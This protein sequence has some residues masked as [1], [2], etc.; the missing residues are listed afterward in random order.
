MNTPQPPT[1]IY[2]PPSSKMPK[3]K[4]KSASTQRQNVAAIQR[5]SSGESGL[6]FF[7]VQA[8]RG[9]GYFSLRR[10]DGKEI[11]GTP[12]GLFSK[13]RMRIS[14]GQIVVAEGVPEEAA[15][16]KTVPYEIIGVIQEREEAVD[17]MRSGKM[18]KEVYK[19]AVTAG[20]L[21][22]IIDDDDL[23]IFDR[24]EEVEEGEEEEEKE[25]VKGGKVQRLDD[26][27]LSEL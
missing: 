12:R 6:T 23:D 1:R 17:L 21:S 3:G 13:G 8:S 14:V 16:I 10:A 7:S 27:D 4:S 5:A 11:L 20:A 22:T 2:P 26:I 18:P 25:K 19:S 9:N 15:K 24:S